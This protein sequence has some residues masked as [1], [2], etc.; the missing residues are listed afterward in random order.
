MCCG[1]MDFSF[2]FFFSFATL[3]SE[4]ATAVGA[5]TATY[6]SFS[7]SP[8]RKSHHSG[9]YHNSLTYSHTTQSNSSYFSFFVKEVET[10]S[11]VCLCPE[12]TITVPPPPS[13]SNIMFQ[14]SSYPKLDCTR[15]YP[16]WT[17]QEPFKNKTLQ[18]TA[19]NNWNL[20][21]KVPTKQ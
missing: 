10:S 9:P 12:F 5:A 4:I 3:Q 16:T 17:K 14:V 20:F 8:Q 7:T 15:P 18:A 13:S 19:N 1:V 11:D 6:S 2:L 21:P